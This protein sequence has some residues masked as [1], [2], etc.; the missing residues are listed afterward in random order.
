MTFEQW[1]AF[2]KNQ[3][4]TISVDEGGQV[5]QLNP[6]EYQARIEQWAQASLELDQATELAGREQDRREQAKA[7]YTKLKNGN[8]TA[9]E[10]QRVV[11][12]LLR[13]EV[14][15]LQEQDPA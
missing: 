7:L 11:A 1:V 5:R 14:R 13:N 8:A 3:Y 4:P 2:L 15:E 12:W 10:T 9:A 6:T